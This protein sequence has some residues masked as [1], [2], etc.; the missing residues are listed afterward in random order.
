VTRPG[1]GGRGPHL[2]DDQEDQRRRDNHPA[3]RAE[4]QLRARCLQARLRPR[5]RAGRA[6]RRLHRPARERRRQAGVSGRMTA[7]VPIFADVGAKVLYLLYLWLLSAI[8]S[9]ELAKRKGYSEK[10]GLGSGLLLS[11]VGLLIWLAIPA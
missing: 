2:R 6:E 4:R 7:Y 5:D 8:L 1:A 10:A 11:A 3:R 9:G